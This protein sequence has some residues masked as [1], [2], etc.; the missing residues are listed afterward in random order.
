MCIGGFYVEGTVTITVSSFSVPS[1]PEASFP[2]LM[3]PVHQMV[4]SIFCKSPITHLLIAIIR[5]SLII[6]ALV[7]HV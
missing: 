1:D 2:F 3:H 7:A 5:N 6:L 4:S